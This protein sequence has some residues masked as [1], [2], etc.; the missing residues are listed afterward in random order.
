MT[1]RRSSIALTL[2][3]TALA[4]LAPACSTT[5]GLPAAT[6]TNSVDTVSLFALSDALTDTAIQNP[7]AYLVQGRLRVRTDQS[8]TLDFAFDV[9]TAGR[10]VLLP[11]GAMRLGMVS[12][13]QRSTTPFDSIKIA[14]TGGYE[15]DSS[16]V[17]G[18]DS[19][20][21]VRSRPILCVTGITV[22]LYAKLQVLVVDTSSAARAAGGRRIAFRIMSDQNCG[23]R[24]LEPGVP[25]Q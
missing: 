2:I 5:T 6:D 10:P 23:Y 7:S 3:A 8:T 15:F 1:A 17:V 22:S 20:L 13:L 24:G 25:K 14:P 9:D 11:A 4:A 16:L 12:G 21:L 18:P 19:L